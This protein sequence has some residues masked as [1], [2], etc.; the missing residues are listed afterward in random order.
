MGLLDKLTQDGSILTDQDGITPQGY[1]QVTSMLNPSTLVGSTLDLNGQTPAEY[2]TN[3]TALIPSLF[4]S[5]LDGYNG[6]TP[7]TYQD[8]V[9]LQTNLLVNSTLPGS[10]LDLEGQTPPQYVNNLPG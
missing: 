10:T 6:Q 1:N 9:L 5:N 2:D 4:Q 3:T 8:Q 7:S